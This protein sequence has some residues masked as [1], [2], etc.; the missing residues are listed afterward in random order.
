VLVTLQ[1]RRLL[2]SEHVSSRTPWRT[3][4]GGQGFRHRFWD[5]L[6]SPEI[7]GG[8]PG[9][10]FLGQAGVGGEVQHRRGKIRCGPGR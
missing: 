9:N 3:L 1:G 4:V 2:H 8:G 6:V 10:P 7:L 5:Q